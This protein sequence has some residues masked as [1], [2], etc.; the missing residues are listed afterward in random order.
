MIKALKIFCVL[1][2]GVLIGQSLGKTE[3]VIEITPPPIEVTVVYQ[4]DCYM[5]DDYKLE[6]V[7]AK[8][9]KELLRSIK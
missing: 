1:L 7:S 6:I 5:D 4:D 2:I 8:E 9:T 3:E